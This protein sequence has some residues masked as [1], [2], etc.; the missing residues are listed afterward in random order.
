MSDTIGNILLCIINGFFILFL[1]YI[2]V[3][4][5]P[6]KK[7]AFKKKI[8]QRKSHREKLRINN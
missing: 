7:D 8:Q 1:I 4:T 3:W 2:A 6:G 5:P